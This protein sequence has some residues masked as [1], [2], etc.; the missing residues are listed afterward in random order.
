[1][2]KF[3]LELPKS[4][5]RCQKC[6]KKYLNS[7][8]FILSDFHP[9]N[10]D[11]IKLQNE[12]EEKTGLYHINA[13]IQWNCPSCLVKLDGIR[14]ITDIPLEI[15]KKTWGKCPQCG[16]HLGIIPEKIFLEDTEDP[17]IN[18]IVVSAVMSCQT[19]QSTKPLLKKITIQFRPLW[20]NI[21]KVKK[22]SIDIKGLKFEIEK[23]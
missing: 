1:M 14:H 18:T 12:Y 8:E 17:M 22:I 20:D 9:Y 10:V 3:T 5:L 7:M 11:I 19:C 13:V 4:V 15:I 21:K 2:E 23:E 6:E 16:R